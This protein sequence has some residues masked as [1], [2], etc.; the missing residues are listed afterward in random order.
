MT[1]RRL[2]ERPKTN[3]SQNAVR[4]NGVIASAVHLAVHVFRIWK[5][6]FNRERTA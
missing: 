3:G 2:R 1:E 4:V 5:V 6:A